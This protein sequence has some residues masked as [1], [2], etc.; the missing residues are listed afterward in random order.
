MTGRPTEYERCYDEQAYKL[1]L[2]GATDKDIASF[3]DVTETTINNWKIAHPL[4][5]ESIK[6]GKM[7]ADMEVAASLFKKATGHKIKEVTFEK[8][9]ADIDLMGDCVDDMMQDI[10]KKRV[11]I[12]EVSPETAAGIFWLKNR[13][14]KDWRDKQDINLKAE[15]DIKPI[16]WVEDQDAG[17]NK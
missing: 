2:L 12:K 17:D 10:Y 11:V 8:I 5:F 16:T 15:L 14:P 4:F 9:D 7:S 6:K 3:F 1:C 13:A